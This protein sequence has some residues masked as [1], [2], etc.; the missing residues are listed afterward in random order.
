ME[1]DLI[2]AAIDKIHQNANQALAHKDAN[3]FISH[4][5]D[6]LNYTDAA[7]TSLSKKQLLAELER[8][9]RNIKSYQTSHY[10][11]K[12]AEED[13]IFTE[14]IARK[15]ILIKPKLFLFTKKQ[16]IQTEEINHWKNINGKWKI[17]AVEIV[18]EEQY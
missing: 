7:G 15:S 14:K 5:D 9:F 3:D 1:T 4:F 16:T 12:S 13:G 11:V 2:I 10:R 6:A 17:I 18:L 8:S